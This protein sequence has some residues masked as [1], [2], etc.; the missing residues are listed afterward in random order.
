M[1]LRTAGV[2]RVRRQVRR[3]PG[4]GFQSTLRSGLPAST[5]GIIRATRFPATASVTTDAAAAS[6]PQVPATW[7]TSPP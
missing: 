7:K 5:R 3:V 2:R 6:A 4:T 1:A